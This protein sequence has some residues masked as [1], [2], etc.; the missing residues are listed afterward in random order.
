M[1]KVKKSFTETE[2]VYEVR[3][4]GKY[5]ATIKRRAGSPMAKVDKRVKKM[6]PKLRDKTL[7]VDYTIVFIQTIVIPVSL[8][9][10]YRHRKDDDNDL[11]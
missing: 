5:E 11:D 10:Y 7:G 4:D 9:W 1:E 8:G 3:I 6:L 2:D